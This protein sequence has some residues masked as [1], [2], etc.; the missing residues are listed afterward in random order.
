[1]SK[2]LDCGRTTVAKH[3]APSAQDSGEHRVPGRSLACTRN[4]APRWPL[5]MPAMKASGSET[6]QAAVALL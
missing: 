5:P 6:H 4:S 2:F 3:P 1:M